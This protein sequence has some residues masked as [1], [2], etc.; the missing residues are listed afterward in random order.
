MRKQSRC[1]VL[2]G[3]QRD[4]GDRSSFPAQIGHSLA[5]NKGFQFA[6][7]ALLRK[8]LSPVLFKKAA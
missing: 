2:R 7:N 5:N 1:M 4:S 6:A 3:G 8:L